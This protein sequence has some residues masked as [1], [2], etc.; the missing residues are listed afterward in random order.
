M[1]RIEIQDLKC[2]NCNKKFN[3]KNLQENQYITFNDGNYVCWICPNC[4]IENFSKNG[5]KGHKIEI[6]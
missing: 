2:F 5:Y 3:S 1:C 6:K 4:G